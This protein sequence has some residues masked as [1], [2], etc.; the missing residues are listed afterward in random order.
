M[1]VESFGQNNQLPWLCSRDF[2]EIIRGLEKTGENPRLA[3]QM[4]WFRRVINL[5]TFRYLGFVGSPFTCSKNNGE[6]GRV[7][8]RLD[9]ALA[10]NEW[11]TKFP[12]KK[13]HH[14][15]ST[16]DHHLL[17]LLFPNVKSRSRSNGKL[18]MFEEKWL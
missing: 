15:A 6:E 5:C 18:F 14:I 11:L 13:L 8:V 2:N 10:N 12:G 16:F 7:Q 4:D 1:I 9:R 17:V 3:R